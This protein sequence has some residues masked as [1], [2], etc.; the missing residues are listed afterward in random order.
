M[1]EEFSV[2]LCPF[3]FLLA[4]RCPLSAV[5]HRGEKMP[6]KDILEP[7]TSKIPE[8]L[9][10]PERQAFVGA[11]LN[12]GQSEE[13]LRVLRETL[14][15][16]LLKM[17]E[18]DASDIDLGG[19]GSA[20]RIWYR[21]HGVKQPDPGIEPFSLDETDMLLQSILTER[22]R[23]H[24]LE[25][26]NLDFSHFIE[27]NERL[28]RFRADMYFD[29]DRLALN[30]R[31][32]N[33]EIRP[34]KSLRLHPNVA[35]VLSLQHVKQGLTLVTGITGSGK[36]S[37][38]DTIIDANNQS[39]DAHIVIIG[40]PIETVH[41]AGRCI[42]RHREVGRD[43]LS[44]KEGA[45]QALRQDPDIIVI[46]EMRDSE[47]I[48][49]ALE[50]TD[51][52]HKVFSTLHTASAVESIDRIIGECPSIEQERVRNRLGDTLLCVISQKLVSTIDGK[53]ALAKEVMLVTPS[54]KAAIKN[55]NA[56][57]IY[58]MI[59]ESGD[60]GMITMEQDLSGLV[61]ARKISRE[62]ALNYANNKRRMQDL[63]RPTI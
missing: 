52:G 6:L 37:T 30:M 17:S 35:R 43:V 22:Q 14:N 12:E 49:T 34:F 44:F 28:I 58:Q 2:P 27:Q 4:S 50:I 5:S 9:S 61:K 23:E 48:M 7:L 26:R 24:L 10:G 40:S 47:T 38:L 39:V 46:G 19:R 13:R 1:D 60:Q 63:L 55:N 41:G 29:L 54:A 20:G 53:L 42:V 59:S 15:G 16:F 21:I 31:F 3:I 32:L 45:I 51:S 36:S 11:L 8:H 57:E 33:A 18:N 62:T 56:S 25:H